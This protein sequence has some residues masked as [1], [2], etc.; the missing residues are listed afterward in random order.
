[1]RIAV[2]LTLSL[3]ACGGARNHSGGDDGGGSGGDVD[4][5]STGSDGAPMNGCTELQGCYTVYAHSDHVLYKID[6]VNKL[7]LTVGP[8]KAPRISGN[9]DTITD[10]AVAT[11]NTIWVVS[12]TNLYTADPNDGHVTLFGSVSV[13][14]ADNI[15]LTFTP[16]GKLYL[17]DHLGAF[18]SVDIST[19]PPMVK[20]LGTI[21]NGD[22]L[23]GDLVALGDGTMYGTVYKLG[24]KSSPRIDS[25]VKIDPATGMETTVVGRTGASVL[26]GLA[27]DQG[28]FFA[29]THD[30]SGGVFTLDPKTGNATLY[31]SFK[32]PMTGMGIKFAGAGVNAMVMPPPPG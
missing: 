17:G 22:A 15:A 25:L 19:K 1:M 21:G 27:F 26:F 14:G 16:D 4:L 7:L 20:T 32:D 2:F 3:A 24:D 31:N 10:L 23:S 6:L 11:D 13:C 18:C 30:G 5:A 28:Q 12:K 29:F 9:E 8:F